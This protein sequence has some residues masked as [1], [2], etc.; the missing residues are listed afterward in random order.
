MS[1]VCCNRNVRRVV[2]QRSGLVVLDSCRA[3]HGRGSK[4]GPPL[5][6]NQGSGGAIQLETTD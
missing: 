4:A 3:A 6:V 1:N 5:A 2:N